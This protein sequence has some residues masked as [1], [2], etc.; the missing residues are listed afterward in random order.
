MDPGAGRAAWGVRRRT[1]GAG[2]DR[3][4]AEIVDNVLSTG[5]SALGTVLHSP[6]NIAAG[7][8]IREGMSIFVTLLLMVFLAVLPLLPIFSRYEV[9]VLDSDPRLGRSWCR[10]RRPRWEGVCQC[11]SG[12]WRMIRRSLRLCVSAQG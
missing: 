2:R 4:G 8:V 3:S 9:S 11:Q 6:G 12:D 10:L 1:P 7:V 5:A